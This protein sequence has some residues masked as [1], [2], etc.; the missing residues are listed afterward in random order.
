M[1]FYFY[2]ICMLCV[3]CIWMISAWFKC[4]VE[5]RCLSVYDVCLMCDVDVWCV[6]V[7]CVKCV[8]YTFMHSLLFYYCY[9]KLECEFWWNG[10]F[11]LTISHLN[12]IGSEC[13]DIWN[14]W[15]S[16]WHFELMFCDDFDVDCCL[17][18]EFCWIVDF[19]WQFMCG[20]W[21]C[22]DWFWVNDFGRM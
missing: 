1:H 3:I 21:S 17:L 7:I 4:Y 8:F 12:S 16:I 20:C 5:L 18:F 11:D 9:H 10:F 14:C 2:L 19:A 15:H 22:D 13:K 6:Y